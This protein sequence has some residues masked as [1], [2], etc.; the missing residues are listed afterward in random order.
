M[1]N[2]KPALSIIASIAILC[3][4]GSSPARADYTMTVNPSTNWGTWQ[5]WGCSL[6]WW[7]NQFGQRS[8]LADTI[9][10]T[11][12]VSLTTNTGTYTLPGLGLNVARYNV[13]GTS[14]Q[15]ITVGGTTYTPNN[16]SSLP[17][18]KM[19]QNY[20]LD[21]GSSNPSSSSWNWTRDANQRSM[22]ALAKARGVNIFE[23]FSNSPPWWMDDNSS[24]AGG[25]N[26][27]D[28]LES[29]NDNSFA[30]YLATVARY[31]YDHWG[32]T[33]QSVEPFNEPS[34]N[35]WNYPASQEGCH[36]DTGLQNT[37]ISDLRS[38]LNNE[39][40]GFMPIAASDENTYD[41]ALSTWNSLTP[42]A[43]SDVAQINTHGYEEGNGRRDLL[44]DAASS[45]GKSLWDS[46]Y[47]E[48]DGSGLS[49]AS[50]LNLD[51]RW[52]HPTVWCYW[53]PFDSGGWGLV[54]SNPGDNWIGPPNPKYFVLAQYTRAIRPGMVMID[55]GDGNTIAAYSS[56]THQLVL[57]TTNYG[58]AQWI[59]YDLSAFHT[60]GGNSGGEIDRW[61]TQTG[62]GD[63]YTYHNDTSLSG[64]KFWSWFPQNTVQTFI[65]NNVTP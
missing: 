24:T 7:A 37:I 65:V 29:W 38:A 8:D 16:P 14:T 60:V 2:P 27:G 61:D 19:I 45:A 63:Q 18:F 59:N 10:T 12:T 25:A 39:G 42:A 26:G 54:Q 15:P 47:G 11:N 5:G 22:M 64:K 21:W 46:E 3:V 57:V 43:Q 34:A 40:L 17:A 32:I 31:A 62:G 6:A 51:L 1:T 23:L 50:N 44:Y 48:S 30:V 20:W 41:E 52:L 58:T 28:N 36:F 35:W 53:Q 55:S 33:F 13:G 49:L 9:F 4:S 56:S